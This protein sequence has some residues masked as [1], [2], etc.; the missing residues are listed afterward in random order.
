MASLTQI[1]RI[2]V[3]EFHELYPDETA[4]PIELID[5][6]IVIMPTPRP[7]H[8]AVVVRLT[9]IIS[10]VAIPNNLGELQVAPS[11]VH[12][13]EVNVVQPDVFFV[14]K[15]GSRCTIGEDGWWEGAPDLCIEII[16][17]SSVK[18]D[19]VDKFDLYEKQG[20]REYWIVEIEGRFVEVYTLSE[21]VFRRQGAYDEGQAFTSA[22]LG[23]T[24]NV[25]EIFAGI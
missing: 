18:N 23:L 16:S 11:D 24:V 6:E 10:N 8:Q 1:K 13:D 5:G 2:T 9:R 21:G 20:V 19:R 4:Q 7:Q 17:P 25:A 15:E 14:A 22:V 3:K 12:F